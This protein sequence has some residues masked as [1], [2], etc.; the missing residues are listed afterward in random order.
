MNEI[1]LLILAIGGVFSF[2]CS[3]ALLSLG[4]IIDRFPLGDESKRKRSLSS[5]IESTRIAIGL[6]WLLFLIGAYAIV[7]DSIY[8]LILGITALFADVLF[9]FTALVLSF[10]VLHA[11][12]RRKVVVDTPVL[13]ATPMP[14]PEVSTTPASQKKRYRQPVSNFMISALMK[15][16]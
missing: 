15:R 9:M 12:R 2:A 14:A 11:M 4:T 7:Q 16:D 8:S 5:P 10:A 3:V 1:L 6:Y 13:Q